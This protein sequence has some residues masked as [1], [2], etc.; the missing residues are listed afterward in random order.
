MSLESLN[1]Y[2][3]RLLQKL[4]FQIK[5]FNY[6]TSVLKAI[7]K[8][9]GN[10]SRY[11]NRSHALFKYGLFFSIGPIFILNNSS[12]FPQNF[13]EFLNTFTGELYNLCDVL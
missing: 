2:V 11:G 5:R 8:I 6:K 13:D 10:N 9:L 3:K 4:T 7:Q 12:S 1:C